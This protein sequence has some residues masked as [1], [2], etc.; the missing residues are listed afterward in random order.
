MTNPITHCSNFMPF[1]VRN[2]ITSFISFLN[3]R[4]ILFKWA[5]DCN[6]LLCGL[7]CCFTDLC[8][9]PGC[10]P[11]ATRPHDCQAFES[12]KAKGDG[13]QSW[14]LYIHHPDAVMFRWIGSWKGPQS[15]SRSPRTAGSH[16]F[17]RF[18]YSPTWQHLHTSINLWGKCSRLMHSSR[19]LDSLLYFHLPVHW[20]S[21]GR[22]ACWTDKDKERE[23]GASKRSTGSFSACFSVTC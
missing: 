23:E 4:M 8:A 17:K 2:N 13:V 14:F 10:R 5:Q 20:S 9:R 22:L 19:G 18:V 6:Q 3:L 7:V 16:W 11:W 12:R 21:G 1:S 15:Y